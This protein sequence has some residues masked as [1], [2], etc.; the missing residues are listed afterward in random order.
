MAEGEYT[1]VQKKLED[2]NRNSEDIISTIEYQFQELREI[3]NTKETEIKAH[4]T[5][6]ISERKNILTQEVQ[7]L[8]K[9]NSKTESLID[10][11]EFAMSY[12]NS[13]FSEGT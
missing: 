4:F 10:V 3:L 6:I 8:E 12:P 1:T 7:G 13:F 2:F 5:Q 11:V 9:I